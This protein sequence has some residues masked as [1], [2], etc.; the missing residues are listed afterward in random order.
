M[1]H[2]FGRDAVKKCEQASLSRAVSQKMPEF[3]EESW[4]SAD[5]YVHSDFRLGSWILA[6]LNTNS[7]LQTKQ[8]HKQMNCA[9]FV[10]MER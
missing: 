9:Q 5:S 2:S 10:A 1:K 7:I 8:F 4:P 6:N 3:R